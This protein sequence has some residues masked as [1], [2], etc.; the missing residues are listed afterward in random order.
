[1]PQETHKELLNEILRQQIDNAA[2][3]KQNALTQLEFA[4]KVSD[5]MN[6]QSLHN[7]RIKHLLE[8]D[9]STNQEGLVEKVNKIEHNFEKYKNNNNKK[10]A[11]ISG[12]A[13]SLYSIGK[14]VMVKILEQ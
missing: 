14:W 1:M 11:F 10:I 8:S 12:V 2:T 7:N 3:L 13:I 5:F 9:S 6:K 4:A